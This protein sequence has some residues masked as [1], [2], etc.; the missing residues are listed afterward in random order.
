MG[1]KTERLRLRG[2]SS[3]ND[4]IAQLVANIFHAPVGRLDVCYSA[5]LGAAIIAAAASGFEWAALQ[6]RFCQAAA[7]SLLL[8]DPALASVY[9]DALDRFQ[10]LLHRKV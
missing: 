4:G 2:G 1:V 3:K 6:D 7:G 10:T 8:P 5:A 9:A